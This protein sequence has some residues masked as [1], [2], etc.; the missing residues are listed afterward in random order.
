MTAPHL[1]AS[2]LVP[3]YGAAHAVHDQW[4][5]RRVKSL[6]MSQAMWVTGSRYL[7]SGDRGVGLW[8][9]SEQ[10]VVAIAILKRP[11]WE[12]QACIV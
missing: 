3:T 11:T 12:R 1:L 7:R 9:L 2:R 5:W 8:I 10:A 4:D 6:P